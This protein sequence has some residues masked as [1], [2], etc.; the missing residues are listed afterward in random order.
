MEFIAW[1]VVGGFW[2]GASTFFV[3]EKNK[4]AK[5]LL[6]FIITCVLTFFFAATFG[7]G[8]WNCSKA[9]DLMVVSIMPFIHLV[10]NA[11]VAIHKNEN[12]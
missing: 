12:K 8:G 3:A 1:M 4:I 10:V 7:Y 9:H 6:S 2:A 11:A 5:S